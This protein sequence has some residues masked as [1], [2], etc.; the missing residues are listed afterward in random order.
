MSGCKVHP[1]PKTPPPEAHPY[2]SSAPSSPILHPA[3]PSTPAAPPA[4]GEAAPTNLVQI[5]CPLSVVA[6][7]AA[8]RRASVSLQAGQGIQQ[9]KGTQRGAGR[10]ERKRSQRNNKVG[11]HLGQWHKDPSFQVGHTCLAPQGPHTFRDIHM[12]WVSPH[13]ILQPWH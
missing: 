10:R 13:H 12:A 6:L 5:P 2:P 11:D 4:G 8:D 1:S 9:V 3:P 7:T